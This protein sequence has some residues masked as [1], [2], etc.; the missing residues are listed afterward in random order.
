MLVWEEDLEVRN[1]IHCYYLMGLGHL[2]H[3]DMEKASEFLGEAY[4]L[5]VNHQ[6]VQRHLEMAGEL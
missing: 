1:K 2:G 4:E 6:G 5:N 3:Q